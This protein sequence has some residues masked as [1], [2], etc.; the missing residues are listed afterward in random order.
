MEIPVY[1]VR[2][3]KLDEWAGAMWSGGGAG[4]GEEV[5]EPAEASTCL[6]HSHSVSIPAQI[7]VGLAEAWVRHAGGFGF[8]SEDGCGTS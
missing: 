7:N 1:R 5:R 6:S 4:G 8:R 2:R 3:V